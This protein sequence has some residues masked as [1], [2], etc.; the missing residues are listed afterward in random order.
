MASRFHQIDQFVRERT[1]ESMNRLIAATRE[2]EFDAEELHH[3]ADAM[4]RSG[5]LLEWPSTEIAADLASTGGPTSLSTLLGPLY[6]RT[7][8]L[9]VPKL[10]VPGRPAG[11]IDVLAQLP[12]Y[13]TALTTPEIRTIVTRCG[14]VHFLA[15]K[16]SAPLDALLF[17]YRQRVGAQNIPSLA[18]SSLL[19]KKI[20]CG[21]KFVGLDVRVAPHGNFGGTFIEAGQ[22]ARKFCAAA[23]IASIRAVALLTD[24]RSPY[25]PFIGR[26]EALLALKTIFDGKAVSALAEHDHRCRL[27]AAHIASLTEGSI[28]QTTNKTISSIFIENIKAQGSSVEAFEKKVVSV[29]AGHRNEF[30]AKTDGFF[31]VDIAALRST[32]ADVH[33]KSDRQFPDEF[34]VILRAAPGSYVKRGELLATVRAN[35][36]DWPILR[37]SLANIFR[38]DKLIEYA[39]GLEETIRG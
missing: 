27:M 12:G 7:R 14:Y 10:G 5:N 6:L 38:T 29:T 34:G 25:Q 33:S 32:F 2:R 21:V 24:G 31:S 9:I 1:E 35:D 39:P 23:R 8:G 17:H 4:A 19:A 20:A 18:I 16:G 28:S 15:D 37:V 26:G 11:G 3:L 13:R 22:S 36:S 30:V